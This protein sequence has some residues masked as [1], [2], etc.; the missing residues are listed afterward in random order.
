[1]RISLVVFLCLAASCVPVRLSTPAASPGPTT[2]AA[3]KL[4]P[5]RDAVLTTA[6]LSEGCA[7]LEERNDSWDALA[8]EGYRSG[9][10]AFLACNATASRNIRVMSEATSYSDADLARE[11]VSTTRAFLLTHD[12]GLVEVP[13]TT[14]RV[15]DVSFVFEDTWTMFPDEVRYAVAFSGG[16]MSHLLDVQGPP[17]MVD[18]AM[19]MALA[20]RQL[21]RAR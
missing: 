16:N 18:F 14:D 20:N 15:G 17:G 13:L 5:P 12:P 4:T 19:A 10:I 3:P 8:F 6:D 9:W 1:M 7:L 11:T 2:Q 21:A